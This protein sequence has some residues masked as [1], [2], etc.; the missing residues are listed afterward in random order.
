MHSTTNWFDI[1]FKTSSSTAIFLTNFK[2]LISIKTFNAESPLQSKNFAV[3]LNRELWLTDRTC[4]IFLPKFEQRMAYSIVSSHH[5]PFWKTS[6]EQPRVWRN[7]S[8]PFTLIVP[9]LPQLPWAQN[10]VQIEST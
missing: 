3:F 5:E 6:C 10:Y 7:D 9:D 4:A 8:F 1:V 2:T